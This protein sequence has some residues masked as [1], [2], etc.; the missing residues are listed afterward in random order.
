MRKKLFVIVIVCCC[1]ALGL[2]ARQ[3]TVAAKP[4]S[5]S[6]PKPTADEAKPTAVPTPTS[7]T[8]PT[9]YP[10]PTKSSEESKP[11]A[12]STPTP[13]TT[14]K[15]TAPPTPTSSPT[16]TPTVTSSPTPTPTPTPLVVSGRVFDDRDGNGAP[17][18]DEPGIAGVAI[19]V[20]GQVV[21]ATNAD[22]QFKVV[23]PGGSKGLLSIVPPQG[24]EWAGGVVQAADVISTGG[25]AIALQRQA[26]TTSATTTAISAGAT[27]V[28]VAALIFVAIASL[29]QA[30]SVHRL[31]RTYR[32]NKALEL[33]Q[34]QA[35]VVAQRKTEVT[36]MLQTEDGWQKVIVQLL[37][38]AL[39]EIGARIGTE[40]LVDISAVPVPRFT[41]AGTGDHLYL[42][43]TAPMVLRS[44]GVISRRDKPIPLDASLHPAARVEVQ[45]VWEHLV[46]ERLPDKQGAALPRQAEWFLV[47]RKRS[48]A[49]KTK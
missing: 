4:T 26:P 8:K 5:P 15:P 9:A 19:T 32:R 2:Q 22:G 7:D 39:P 38:D 37:A 42:F 14:M 44:A 17:D 31:E 11:T 41:L 28:L 48:Q 27:I 13:S 18:S 29:T 21:A 34:L 46:E 16:S 1:V 23:V 24:W 12:P 33:E 10:T 3:M 43:T 36:A 35:Q 30:T 6:T 45:A 49:G 20:D 47:V 40:G 25:M